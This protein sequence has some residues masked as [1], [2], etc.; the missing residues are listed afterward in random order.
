MKSPKKTLIT[1]FSALTVVQ[2]ANY[3][4]PLVILPYLVRVIGPAKFGVLAFAQAVVFYFTLL[5]DFGINLYAPREIALLKEDQKALSAIVS[6]VLL[7][8]ALFLCA[9]LV[10]YIAVVAVVP[11]FRDESLVFILSAGYMIA[12]SFLPT[13][14]F[15]GIEKMVNITMGLLVARILSL[16]LIFSFI[17]EKGDYVWVPLIN[18]G[19][20]MAGV[21]LMYVLMFYREDIKLMLPSKV[22]LRKILRESI[23]L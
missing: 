15:Q 7:I 23:P 20:L 19:G 9:S 14:F 22:Q 12:N 6:G 16:V 18:S 21:L 8:K 13:W 3:I 2:L 5:P 1:N 11:R 4:L 17:R 10:L